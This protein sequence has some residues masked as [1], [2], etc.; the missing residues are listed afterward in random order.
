[1]TTREEIESNDNSSMLEQPSKEEELPTPLSTSS[2]VTE[3]TEMVQRLSC[4]IVDKSCS[5]GSNESDKEED[6]DIKPT[7]KSEAG[8]VHHKF[9]HNDVLRAMEQ[10]QDD[11]DNSSDDNY[12]SNDELYYSQKRTS[13]DLVLPSQRYKAYLS[14]SK[15]LGNEYYNEDDL[16][17]MQAQI[18]AAKKKLRY[19]RLKKQQESGP[20]IT[21]R[22]YDYA[23][24]WWSN[25]PSSPSNNLPESPKKIDM[26]E[27]DSTSSPDKYTND[28]LITSI[29][30]QHEEHSKHPYIL[31]QE[32]MLQIAQQ[33]LPTS[34][35][36]AQ[37]KRLYSLVR[38]GDSFATML[39]KVSKHKQTLLVIKTTNDNIFG[40]FVDSPWESQHKHSVG[41]AFYG[42]AQAFLYSVAQ[43]KINVYKW[44]GKNRYIQFCD[45]QNKLLAMGGGGK[46]GNFG[47]C[48]EDDFRRGSTGRCETFDNDCLV[49]PDGVDAKHDDARFNILDLEVWG[50]FA[51]F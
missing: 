45:V 16:I 18:E 41:H 31:S 29:T 37:W 10:W 20:G 3:M 50:F 13:N 27:R 1:M 28:D 6:K 11:D 32:L 49:V 14:N 48:V 7:K 33:G 42:S 35:A 17:L 51:G 21:T 43:N 36:F 23:R 46:D 40:C 24:S 5:W 34:V 38:D 2:S 47:L 22:A 15:Y 4:K 25:I 19:E 26:E 44:T 30:I 9:S 8:I 39:R 12:D